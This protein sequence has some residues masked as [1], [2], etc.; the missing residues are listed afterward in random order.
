V[1]APAERVP[2]ATALAGLLARPAVRPGDDADL[3]LLHVPWQAACRAPD[4]GLVRM[5]LRRGEAAYGEAPE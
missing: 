5:T 4:A 1:L 2:A 3:C